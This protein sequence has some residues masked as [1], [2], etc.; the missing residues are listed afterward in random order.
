MIEK[1]KIG[2][3]LTFIKVNSIAATTISEIVV[4]SIADDRIIFAHKRKRYYLNCDNGTL[5]LKGHNLGITQGTWGNGC[6]FLMSGNCNI[7]G[8]DLE[9]MKVLLKTNINETFNQWERIYWFD[10]TSK[11]GD[12]IFMPRPVSDNYLRYREIAEQNNSKAAGQINI[13]DFIYNYQ[14]GSKHN[15][16]T[17]MLKYHLTYH[18]EFGERLQLGKIVDIIEMSEEAFD[19]LEYME[20]DNR[21]K[22]RGGNYSDDLA[23]DRTDDSYS[24]FELETFYSHLTLIRT[25]SGRA[26]TADA[27]GYDYMRY[28]GLLSHY[29]VSMKA[30]CDK[31]N[32]LLRIAREKAE[33]ERIKKEEETTRLRN[34]EIARIE[35]EYSF[36]TV[37]TDKYDQ[38][39]AANNLRT[40]LKVKFPA[41]KFSVKK[42]HYDSYTVSWEDGPS[43]PQVS[44][45]TRLFKDEGWD[46]MN[47]SSYSINTPFNQRY[48][49]IGYISTNRNISDAVRNQELDLLN[50]ELGK[51]YQMEDYVVER[52]NTASCLVHQRTYKK[53]YSPEVKAETKPVEKTNSVTKNIS[54]Q[55]VELIDYSEK[56]FA[57][58]G[59]T[60][61]IK[62]TLSN[63]GG[64][65]N[66]RLSC[67]PGWIFSKSRID[68]VK[69]TLNIK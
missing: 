56:S 39:T 57:I 62:E 49:G 6:C 18:K 35:K 29:R 17:D 22:D 44:E 69:Q 42:Y 24:K 11:E 23:E 36:L 32:E 60:K 64:S 31:V 1:V 13:E 5:V 14:K 43:D 67:G 3:K 63:L 21:L 52:N 16:L 25:P 47:D 41:T 33:E 61:P 54:A 66:G 9:T 53:D 7:G 65:Y 58:I 34:E 10:G 30:D 28:T 8:L 48:G 27:Q 40:L 50:K 12:P 51:S 55:D 46:G 26:I 19:S 4:D 45:I 59:E 37:T 2:D 68:T 20:S 38:K 15:N